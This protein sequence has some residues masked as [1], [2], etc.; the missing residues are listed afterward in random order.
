MLFLVLDIPNAQTHDTER[1]VNRKYPFPNK[2]RSAC[3]H[4]LH[5]FQNAKVG[6]PQISYGNRRFASLRTSIIVRFADLPQI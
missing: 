2:Q 1:R 5:V 3:Y 6:G 4:F